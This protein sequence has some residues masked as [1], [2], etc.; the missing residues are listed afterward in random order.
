ND[1]TNGRCGSVGVCSVLCFHNYRQAKGATT[2]RYHRQAEHSL[3][4]HPRKPWAVVIVTCAFPKKLTL[5]HG[6]PLR[7]LGRAKRHQVAE[8]LPQCTRAFAC[9]NRATLRASSTNH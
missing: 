6:A 4:P 7:V 2:R 9:L 8:P 5:Y 3:V 1:A